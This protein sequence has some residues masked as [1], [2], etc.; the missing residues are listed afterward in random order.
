M[1]REYQISGCV[2]PRLFGDPNLV[3][4]SVLWAQTFSTRKC[5]PPTL[6]PCN[7]S[8][9]IWKLQNRRN[10]QLLRTNTT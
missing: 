3:G 5:S 10:I 9:S 8:T 4:A 1:M 6:L 2:I 7:F